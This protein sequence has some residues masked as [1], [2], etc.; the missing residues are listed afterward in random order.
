[1]KDFI[2]YLFC[3]FFLLFTAWSAAGRC[4]QCNSRNPLCEIYVNA[5]LQIDG[6]PCNGQCYTRLNRDDESTISR[7][8]S[9]EHG[10]MNPQTQKSL[11]LSGNSVWVFCDTP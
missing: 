10:F 9:W 2:G 3:L 11:I 5:T 4:Y 6:T 7:G 8:C 1:M